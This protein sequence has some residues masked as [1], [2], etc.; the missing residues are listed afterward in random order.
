MVNTKIKEIKPVLIGQPKLVKETK[1]G[2]WYKVKVGS[3]RLGS[4]S[5]WKPMFISKK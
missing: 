2:Y 1:S 5:S 3:N 4:K